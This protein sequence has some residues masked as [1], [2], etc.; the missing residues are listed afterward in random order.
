MSR[1]AAHSGEGGVK[2]CDIRAIAAGPVG[3]FLITQIAAVAELEAGSDGSRL[4]RTGNGAIHNSGQTR[5]E[6]LHSNDGEAAWNHRSEK[7]SCRTVS[8]RDWPKDP[9]S[10]HLSRTSE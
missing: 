5:S 8:G 9:F 4:S 3:K 10:G 2:F 1:F 7:Q 6:R